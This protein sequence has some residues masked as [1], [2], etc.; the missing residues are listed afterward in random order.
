[1][2]EIERDRDGQLAAE[3]G[4]EYGCTLQ[5][6]D[7]DEFLP[8]II[9]GDLSGKLGD[10]LLDGLFVEQYFEVLFHP[11]PFSRSLTCQRYPTLLEL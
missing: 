10:L 4:R 11:A 1:M 6:A 3:I 2:D 8:P 9:K 5:D 7:Q